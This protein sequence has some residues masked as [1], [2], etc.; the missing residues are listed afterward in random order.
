MNGFPDAYQALDDLMH[1]FTLNFAKAISAVIQRESHLYWPFLISSIATALVAWRWLGAAGATRR[2]WREFWRE[3][4]VAY[5]FGRF[6]MRCLLHDVSL[7]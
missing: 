5:D 6:A 1:Y 4:F 7:L 3:Y 2:S